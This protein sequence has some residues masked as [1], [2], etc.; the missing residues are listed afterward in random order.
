MTAT[1]GNGLAAPKSS[2]ASSAPSP[3]PDSRPA[4]PEPRITA[5]P[6]APATPSTASAAGDSIELLVRARYP[7]LY[8]VSWEE[9]R[10]EQHLQAIAARRNKQL[11]VWSI[12]EG[13]REAS[14]TPG[15]AAGKK[16][17][18]TDPIEALDV[19][20]QHKEPAIYLFNDLNAFLRPEIACNRPIIR[21]VR[22]VARALADS[23]K[24]LV[25]CSPL[26]ELAPELQ[27]DV[28]V[29]DFS[30]PTPADIDAL[31]DR[32]I[33]DVSQ[34]ASITV[35]L[36]PK[37]REALVRAAGGLTLQ[38]AENVFAKTLVNDGT[39]NGEDVS[40]VFAEKQQIIRKSGLLEYYEASDALDDVGGLDQLKDWL[41]RRAMAFTDQ[42]Q[43]FGLPA[44]KGVLLVGV[45]G[46]GKSLCAKAVSREWNM[47]LLRFDMGRMFASLVGSSEQNIRRAIAV[48]ESIAPA[49]MWIDEID[50]AFAGSS[51]SAGADGGTTARVMSTFLTWL[52]EKSKPVFVLATANDISHLPPE[53]LRKG[54]LDEIFFVDLPT[55]EE[56]RRVFEIHIAKRKRNAAAIDTDRLAAAAAGF[57][58]AEIEQAVISALYDAFY[59][60]RD[61]TTDDILRNITQTV[62]LSRTMSERIESLRAWA[63]GRARA[64]ST[65]AEVEPARAGGRKLEIG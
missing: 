58:G 50:K 32:I 26:L 35:D 13:I 9:A 36:S 24:T 62:P 25:I 8:I 4:R 65:P 53:L 59:L 47:P 51:G 20:I 43:K 10:V 22:E 55:H 39:L 57:S 34:H 61:L 37:G 6:P 44:P 2:P 3:A 54:R 11:H 56:R 28:C 12:T 64:A 18:V 14:A 60:G 5:A 30:L 42:A 7:V 41:K 16:R 27:K 15:Q 17:S 46:C 33:K 63:D 38:E 23:Y 40:T 49:I 1:P 29:V 48:A 52:S 45:Q 31:L 21:K 19:V